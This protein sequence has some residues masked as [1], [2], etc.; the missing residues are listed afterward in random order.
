MKE[1]GYAGDQK[2]SSWSLQSAKREIMMAIYLYSG[3][4]GQRELPVTLRN[5]D[6]EFIN[7]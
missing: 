3:G 4:A 7:M 5:I 2:S 1:S 6:W